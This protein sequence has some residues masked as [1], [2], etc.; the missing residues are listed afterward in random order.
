MIWL[1]R[2]GNWL[3]NPPSPGRVKLVL[4]VVAMCFALV[5]I[6]KL[7]LWPDWLQVN[8]LRR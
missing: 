8:K 1:L 5:A 2:I 6:E 7:G 4:A 3:R